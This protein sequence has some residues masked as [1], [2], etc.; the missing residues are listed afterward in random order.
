MILGQ[1]H[2]EVASRIRNISFEV[3]KWSTFHIFGYV[4]FYVFFTVP[5]PHYQYD[6]KI[7]SS[8]FDVRYLFKYTHFGDDQKI[9]IQE[10]DMDGATLQVSYNGMWMAYNSSL[11]LNHNTDL[12]YNL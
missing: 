10:I 12:R 4:G 9:A 8:S 5:S 3:T 11:I 6:E 1:T 7:L 2:L